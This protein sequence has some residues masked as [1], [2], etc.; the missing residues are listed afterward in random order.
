MKFKALI[1]ST[2]L[3]GLLGSAALADTL[4]VAHKDEDTVGFIDL[5]TGEMVVV[6]RSGQN[7]HEMAVSPDGSLA[8]TG[9]TN[10]RQL[11]LY[12]VSTGALIRKIDLGP[13][14]VRLL[15]MQRSALSL[16]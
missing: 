10:Q 5:E 14:A 7:P 2:A 11:Y 13:K 3:A 16:L 4:V 9:A 15:Q 1:L 6:Q 12:H 8:I